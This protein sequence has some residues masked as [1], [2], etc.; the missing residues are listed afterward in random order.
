MVQKQLRVAQW[1]TG[2]TGMHSL[3][4]VIEHPRYDLVSL[5][6]YS[7]EKVGRDAGDLCG[8]E[9][10]GVIATRNIEDVIAAQPDC[11]MYMPLLDHESV[12]DMCRLLESGANIV[13]TITT[14]RHPPTM[15]R[16]VR[17]RLEAACERGGSSL[18]DTG[19][20][21]GFITEVVPL[22]MTLMERRLERFSI[23]QYADVSARKSPQFLNRI[24]G[25]DPSTPGLAEMIVGTTRAGDS[26]RQTADA[27]S[28]P[29][30]DVVITATPAVTVKTEQIDVTTIEAGTV[31]AWR[32]DV[33]GMRGGEP[34]L[35]FQR[36]MFVTRELDPA[37]EMHDTGWHVVVKG[38]APMDIT[39][40]FPPPD[41]YNPISAGYNAHLP[42]N[43]IAAVCDAQPGILTTDQ[44]RLVPT[45][46]E[47]FATR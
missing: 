19:S 3:R 26:L 42:V 28:L 33:I 27:L 4:K 37:W 17:K 5:Y 36:N 13:T 47:S 38:D 14:V 9:P 2:H 35:E 23:V 21:P 25:G 7:E 1:A 45:F 11:V 44:L 16:D 46:A 34:L 8:T 40:R 22:A 30:D 15:D 6:T 32:V 10:T 12:D 39:I 18:Y 41:V 43:S 20:G 24:F 31:G 29:L